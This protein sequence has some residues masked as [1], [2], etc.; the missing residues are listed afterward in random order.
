[1]AV[2]KVNDEVLRGFEQELNDRFGSVKQ[3]LHQLQAVIDGVE[4]K[5]KGM[6]AVSFDRKQREI[7]ERMAHIGNLLVR[8]QQAVDDNRR[9][10]GSTEQEVFQAL[11][12][13]D[14]GAGSGAGAGGGS[15]SFN[16]M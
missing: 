15:S 3:Q 1:M 6:G 4:G 13:I 16:N 10:V 12:G 8:F 5:W 9:I 2:Q 14:A 7:N 11:K